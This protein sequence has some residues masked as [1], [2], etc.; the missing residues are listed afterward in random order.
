MM[1]GDQTQM[2]NWFAP[3]ASKMSWTCFHIAAYW[4]GLLPLIDAPELVCSAHGYQ[5]PFISWSRRIAIG[6]P[7]LAMS[8]AYWCR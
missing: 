2:T 8:R 1:F 4:P 3:S 7:R 6:R 5:M